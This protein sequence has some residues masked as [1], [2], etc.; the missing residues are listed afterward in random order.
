MAV[1]LTLIDVGTVHTIELQLSNPSLASVGL[2][3]LSGAM[4]MSVEAR[5]RTMQAL[6]LAWWSSVASALRF[7]AFAADRS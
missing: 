3:T 1:N 2:G 5:Q 4:H 7:R 6:Y